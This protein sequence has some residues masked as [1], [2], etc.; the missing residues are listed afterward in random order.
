MDYYKAA[1]N[2]Q[3]IYI[4]LTATAE[5]YKDCYL[6]S[7]LVTLSVMNLMRFMQPNFQKLCNFL[8]QFRV[9]F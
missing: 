3:K 2:T 1:K 7:L 6:I 9:K 8:L 4:F 5:N